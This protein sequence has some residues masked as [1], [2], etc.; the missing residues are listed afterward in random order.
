MIKKWVLHSGTKS[1]RDLYAWAGHWLIDIETHKSIG[2][3]ITS[4]TGDI[5]LASVPE[6]G[7]ARG[8]AL[9]RPGKHGATLKFVHGDT[10]MVRK[11]L[12]A[13]AISEARE[14]GTAKISGRLKSD[15][16]ELLEAGFTPASQPKEPA[17]VTWTM[18]LDA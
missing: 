11:A 6:K 10:A 16:A 3:A 1:D 7:P 4:T 9:L 13:R 18:E 17:Y 14:L 2:N 5:W 12:L 15:S 8:F